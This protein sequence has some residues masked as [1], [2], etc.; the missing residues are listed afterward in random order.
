MVFSQ[1]GYAAND[2]SL[3]TSYVVTKG[4]RRMWLRVG[5]PGEML[6]DFV[7]WFDEN[8][9]DIDSGI[10]DDWSYAE[11]PIR[12]SASVL[13]NHASGTAVD[14]DATRW[15]LGVEPEAYLT[16]A[17][18]A[19][20]RAKLRE[21]EGCIR[22]GGDYTGR[23]DPM[24]FEINRDAATVARV[25][26]K[27]GGPSIEQGDDMYDKAARDEV[28]GRLDRILGLAT[29]THSAVASM[30]VAVSDRT[31]G[32]RAIVL[33]MANEDEVEVDAAELAATLAPLLVPALTERT[34]ASKAEVEDAIRSVL[35]GLDAVA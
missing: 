21:Y 7:L 6:A 32:I 33:R 20:V 14:V 8:V 30:H 28:V 22:W 18:I 11:R 35:G 5:P 4:G 2:R 24:H 9:R 27:I 13:S 19:K 25:W 29:A 12:G 10:L 31:S 23:K 1:N 26:A 34:G 16:A 15:P 17:E 3:I